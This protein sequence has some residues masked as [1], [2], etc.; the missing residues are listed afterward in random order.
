MESM[1][2]VRTA[3]YEDR[4]NIAALMIQVWLHTYA[5][6]GLRNSIS[7]YVLTE[8]TPERI[9]QSISN[10]DRL[11]LV[12]EIND[13]IV[14]VAVLD[15]HRV[16]PA[17]NL[18]MPELQKLYV[19]EHFTKRGIGSLLLESAKKRCRELAL[20]TMWLTV[21]PQNA[22]AVDFYKKKNFYHVGTTDFVLENELHENY[23][24]H[25]ATT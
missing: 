23:V 14:G 18:A 3:K 2:M 15:R 8:F 19:L 17:T 20:P 22:R 12:A 21:Q 4:M 16:C 11:Y 5:T 10:D 13:H 24:L 9:G 25:T 7:R 1:P 6:D